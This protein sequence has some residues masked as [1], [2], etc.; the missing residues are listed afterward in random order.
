VRV[1]AEKL[2]Y[3]GLDSRHTRHTSDQH[4]FVNILLAQA[5]VLQR[6]FARLYGAF[7]QFGK[8]PS[9]QC[10]SFCFFSCF[11]GLLLFNK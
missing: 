3:L 4:H 8:G 5:C 2:F 9:F 1:L 7:D 6:V 11:I 10:V